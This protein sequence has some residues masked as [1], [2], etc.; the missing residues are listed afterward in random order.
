MIEFY[1]TDPMTPFAPILFMLSR[2]WSPRHF[3]LFVVR[4]EIRL[5]GFFENR[6]YTPVII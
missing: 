5:K 1:N 6:L 3:L 4:K 2:K